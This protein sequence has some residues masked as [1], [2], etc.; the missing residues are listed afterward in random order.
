ML[1]VVYLLICV[2]IVGLLFISVVLVLLCIKLMFVYKLGLIFRLSR[3]SLCNVVIRCCFTEFVRA[4][5]VCV[6]AIVLL[7]RCEINRSAVCYVSSLVLRIIICRRISKRILRLCAVV[8]VRI[9]S[10]FFL[11]SFGGSF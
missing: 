6:L 4:N 7:L 11:I 3:L 9:C 1:S 2:V 5:A 8:F 10:I